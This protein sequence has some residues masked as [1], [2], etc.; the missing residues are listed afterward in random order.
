MLGKV[1]LED[2]VAAPAFTVGTA[3]STK[4]ADVSILGTNL[5]DVVFSLG[6]TGISWAFLISIT[7]LGFAIISNQFDLDQLD[8]LPTEEK[9]AF[10]GGLA[11]ITGIEFVPQ[12]NEV[13]TTNDVLSILALALAAV[14]YYVIAYRQYSSY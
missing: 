2:A 7:A 12:I 9:A 6:G 5:S 10:G 1:N 13:V 8:S 3:A 14:T 11:T 4:M